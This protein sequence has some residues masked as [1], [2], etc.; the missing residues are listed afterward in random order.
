ML[1]VGF[2]FSDDIVHFILDM[3]GNGNSA[4]KPWLVFAL[5]GLLVAATAM[6]K[7]RISF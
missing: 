7:W 4:A 5:D 3:T 2:T 1:V 6:L